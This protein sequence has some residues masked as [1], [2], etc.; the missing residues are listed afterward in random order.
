MRATRKQSMEG[1]SR[2][3][4]A[5]SRTVSDAREFGRASESNIGQAQFDAIT[6]FAV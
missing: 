4:T 3:V 5:R 6:I 2:L 1:Q